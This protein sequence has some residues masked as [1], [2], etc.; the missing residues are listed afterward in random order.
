MRG[1]PSIKIINS[2]MKKFI[3]FLVLI[4]LVVVQGCSSNCS[5]HGGA[6]YAPGRGPNTTQAPMSRD[7]IVKKLLAAMQQLVA[8]LKAQHGN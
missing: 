6:Q 3:P 8:L 4:A 5:T 2:L 7:E 1:V